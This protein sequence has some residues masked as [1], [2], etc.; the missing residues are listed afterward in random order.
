MKYA[1]EW[2]KLL[3]TSFIIMGVVFLSG[4]IGQPGGIPTSTIPTTVSVSGNVQTKGLGTTPTILIFTS[5]TGQTYSAD[6]SNGNYQ[7]QLP[8]QATYT[9]VVHWKSSLG[10]TGQCSPQTFQVNQGAGSSTLSQ[11]WYC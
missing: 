5:S 2:Q 7:I 3:Y 10:V 8:N 6:V 11:N 9:V 4:C 1:L